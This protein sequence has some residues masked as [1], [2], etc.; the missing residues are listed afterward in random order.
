MDER[1]FRDLGK[2]PGQNPE[3]IGV[4]LVPSRSD[5][6]DLEGLAPPGGLQKVAWS[7]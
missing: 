4:G 5:F 3:A 2:R 7:G 6:A 1:V